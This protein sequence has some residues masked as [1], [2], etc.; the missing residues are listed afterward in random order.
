MSIVVR[1][2]LKMSCGKTA[3]Q[4]GHAVVECVLMAFKDGKWKKWLDQW[5]EEGQKKVV[6]AVEDLSRL[7]E[8]YQKAKS[9]GLPTAMVVDAGLT[10]LPPGTSTAACVGPAPDELIDVVTGRLKLYK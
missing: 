4:V 10:E 9:L 6:L 2:D 1:V 3:A 8:V 7:Q 5:L